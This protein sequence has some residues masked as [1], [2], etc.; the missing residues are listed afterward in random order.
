MRGLT[1]FLK[2]A[3][4]SLVVIIIQTTVMKLLTVG[5]I[6]A[7][8]LTIWVVYVALHEGRLEGTLIGF[9]V[10]LLFDFSAGNFLGL[11]A[12]FQTACG[13]FAGSFYNEN[14]TQ[15]TLGTYRFLLIVLFSSFIQ[16]LIYFLI[17]TRGSEIGLLGAV[18]HFGLITTLFTTALTL[19]PLLVFS[20][21]FQ[22]SI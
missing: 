5:G 10:G 21:K 18:F 9:A 7:D 13:F 12:L 17:F 11:S 8:I 1:R 22:S 6:T 4:L 14:K 15:L 3:L 16:N 2:Y 20:R 19:L